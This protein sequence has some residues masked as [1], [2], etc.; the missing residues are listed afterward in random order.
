MRKLMWFTLGFAAACAMGI[1][2]LPGPLGLIPGGICLTA[3]MILLFVNKL[4]VRRA[5]VLL[6]GFFFGTLWVLGYG[7]LYLQPLEA[8]HEK[9]ASLRI[10]IT[11]YH[12]KGREIYQ[13]KTEIQGKSYKIRF[14]LPEQWDLAPGDTVEGDFFLR[15]AARESESLQ[16][17]YG[18]FLTGYAKDDVHLTMTEYIPYR[19][20]HKVL[21]QKTRELLKAVCPE[22]TLGFV[23][24]VLLGDTVALSYKDD[25]AL[26]R[27]GLRHVAAVSGLHI[28]VLFGLIMV[29][30]RRKRGIAA[31]IGIPVLLLFAGMTGFSPSVVR[32]CLMELL[33]ICSMVSSRDYDS[34]TALAFGVL[35]MLTYNP[36]CIGS[37]S[38]QL[39]V[40]SIAGILLF[41]GRIHNYFIQKTDRKGINKKALKV[42]LYRTVTDSI[43]AT[44]G[45][46]AFTVPL[47]AHYFGTVSVIGFVSNFLLLGLIS[48]VFCGALCTGILSWIWLP[49]GK[50]AAWLLAWPVRLILGT[51]GF[52]GKIPFASISTDNVYVTAWLIFAYGMVGL[53]LL[54][55]KKRPIM[56]TCCLL[57]TLI[58]TGVF[59]FLENSTARYQ[60]TVLDAGQ[61]LCVLLRSGSHCYVVDCG[62][63]DPERVAEDA[64]QMLHRQGIWH[65]D[66]LILTHYD[67]DHV[68]G[69]LPLLTQIPTDRLYL[70]GATE[71]GDSS[72]MLAEEAPCPVTWV[73][74]ITHLLCGTARLTI[75][76]G[77]P[78]VTGNESSLCALFRTGKCDILVTGDRG[79]SGEQDLLELTALP[80]LEVLIAGHHGSDSSTG[81]EL[82]RRTTPEVAVISAGRD[83]PFGHPGA[84]TLE[85]LRLFGC[86]VLRTDQMGTIV[87]RG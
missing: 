64:T 36:W 57:V 80:D 19:Y 49:L 31:L 83:N 84:R 7:K 61:G 69:A 20:V 2:L 12:A 41:T 11:D 60:V 8:Y 35:C 67:R 85:R 76:P 65:L 22:D 73:T 52:L 79:F 78:G 42:R 24:A 32:A 86:R 6:L 53:F 28:S 30:S 72:A 1:W 48:A 29:V 13:G 5:A 77:K 54:S 66:G 18:M 4:N 87:F 43:A 38:F 40:G 68:G 63:D 51:A 16:P 25:L 45:A 27:S 82:L 59:N 70:S 34:P 39:S 44:A 9:T 26:R 14:F 58:F 17:G 81:L 47:C 15:A 23:Q 74:D 33:V 46:M 50:G 10:E 75:Y 56:L 62:G 37:V 55:R 21:G 3:G 71:P